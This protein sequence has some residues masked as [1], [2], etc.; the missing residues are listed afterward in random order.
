M[1]KI[2]GRPIAV[3][4]IYLRPLILFSWV[5]LTHATL[6]MDSEP[7]PALDELFFG[8][9]GEIGK[10]VASR[11]NAPAS[12]FL[13]TKLPLF[14]HADLSELNAYIAQEEEME[15]IT[16]PDIQSFMA[17]TI[18]EGEIKI[19]SVKYNIAHWYEN[20]SDPIN[21]EPQAVYFVEN[22][23]IIGY[24]V[25]ALASSL[26]GNKNIFANHIKQLPQDLNLK[27]HLKAIPRENWKHRFYEQPRSDGYV[28]KYGVLTSTDPR[29][30][31]VSPTLSV[32][33]FYQPG[34]GGSYIN[35]FL[36]DVEINIEKYIRF[37]EE[38]S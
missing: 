31:E 15:H 29:Y 18:Q 25:L 16:A 28:E 17:R 32:M 34:K 36:S 19:V 38:R 6:A 35:S 14:V 2:I 23:R 7:M 12:N 37:M 4:K 1:V 27:A 30:K 24:M 11:V 9:Q 26:D 10:A 33:M 3:V 13:R 21:Y 8:P 5:L 20:L 22:N